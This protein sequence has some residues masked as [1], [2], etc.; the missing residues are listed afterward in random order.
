MSKITCYYCGGKH[1]YEKCYKYPK[2]TGYTQSDMNGTYF[3][4]PEK[5]TIIDKN[6]FS[7]HI[8]FWRILTQWLDNYE[9]L[10]TKIHGLENRVEK[11]EDKK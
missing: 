3:E 11:L 7:E 2:G 4:Q 1:S 5:P 10:A 8:N 9:E 6:N